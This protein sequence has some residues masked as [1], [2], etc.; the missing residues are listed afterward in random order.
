MPMARPTFK[1]VVVAIDYFTKWAEAK[2]LATISSKKVQEFVWESIIYR[3]GIP[4]DI[5]SD[6]GM[7][8]NNKYFRVFCDDLEIK[9]SFSSIDHPQTNGQVE[10]ISKIIKFNL[11]MKLEEHKGVWAEELPKVLWAYRTTA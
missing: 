9:K 3:F 4:H 11:K 10:A 2:P 1:Y 6:N 7:Q 5:I 8:F